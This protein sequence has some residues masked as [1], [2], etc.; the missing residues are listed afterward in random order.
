MRKNIIILRA[1]SL[2]FLNLHKIRET[3]L[4]IIFFFYKK[5][6]PKHS[7]IKK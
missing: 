7:R 2:D 5:Q 6:R 4:L 1:G 3:F